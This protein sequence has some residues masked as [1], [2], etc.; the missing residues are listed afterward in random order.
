MQSDA[1]ASIPISASGQFTDQATVAI[2][3]CRVKAIYIVPGAA[4]GTVILRDGGSGGT[5]RA[6]INTVAS[7]AAPTYLLFPG[8]GLLFLTNVY[9]A[10]TNAAFATIIYG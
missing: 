2:G 9:G 5:I 7:V 4:A 8:E 1:S 6:T 10:V 3:R